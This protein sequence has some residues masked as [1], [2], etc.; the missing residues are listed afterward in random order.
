MVSSN[1]TVRYSTWVHWV[2]FW[3]KIIFIK[4][5]FET[6]IRYCYI[7]GWRYGNHLTYLSNA[8]CNAML[9]YHVFNL[10]WLDMSRILTV[11]NECSIFYEA[12]VTPT[13]C[14]V[15]CIVRPEAQIST[16]RR[17][18][19]IWANYGLSELWKRKQNSYIFIKEC[20]W[21][22]RLQNDENWIRPQYVQMCDLYTI[23]DCSWMLFSSEQ[24]HS[25]YPNYY[26]YSEL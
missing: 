14:D 12:A 11:V 24:F 1:T 15:P 3:T 13:K 26:F 7:A 8:K 19:I 5:R 16:G 10:R 20:I 17:Q 6:W 2:Q 23:V 18:A 9:Q 4:W 21:K 22:C 25:E